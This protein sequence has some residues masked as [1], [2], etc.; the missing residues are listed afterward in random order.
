MKI[1]GLVPFTMQDFPK[2]MACVVFT[3]GCN[4]SC[5]YCHNPSLLCQQSGGE[6][7]D[8]E[9]IL[10]F[11]HSRQGKLN[12][13][14]ISGGEP[15]LQNGLA[16]F[17]RN[18]RDVGMAIKLDTNGTHPEVVRDLIDQ[19]LLDYVAMDLKGPEDR[20]TEIC[21][22]L[23]DTDAVQECAALL[24]ENRVPYEFRTTF[25]P[26]LSQDDVMRMG[27]SIQ[28]AKSWF[29]QQ[30]RPGNGTSSLV[31]RPIAA[32]PHSNAV[33]RQTQQMAAAH[34]HIP[35]HVRGV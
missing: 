1:A 2:H 25:T 11:L 14:V 20:Y 31:N 21:G 6:K 19:G 23:V 22:G 15:T 16:E 32:A 13:V 12:G 3:P 33:V 5:H 29:L 30:Y 17:I 9:S 26:L 8:E 18:V 10:R 7:H 35:V 4:M 28:G 27:N 34:F 24:M